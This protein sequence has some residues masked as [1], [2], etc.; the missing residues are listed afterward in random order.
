MVD[1][2]AR[3]DA[4]NVPFSFYSYSFGCLYFVFTYI[5]YFFRFTRKPKQLKK[6]EKPYVWKN[7]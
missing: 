3:D 1:E 2:A 4:R 5:F 7:S 6:L